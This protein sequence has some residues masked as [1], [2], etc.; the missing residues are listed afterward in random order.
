MS[1]LRIAGILFFAGAI[2]S[3]C[4]KYPENRLK[5]LA[6]VY[7]DLEIA[8]AS[9]TSSDSLKTLKIKVF[10]KYSLTQNEYDSL[11]AEI[12]PEQETW[13]KFFDFA[14]EYIDSLKLAEI[15]KPDPTKKD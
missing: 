12:P 13:N 5:K 6:R 3:G 11:L 4:S 7:A 14:R 15:K 10:E 1:F 9:A 2:L 8:E